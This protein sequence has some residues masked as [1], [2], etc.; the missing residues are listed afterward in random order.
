MWHVWGR[1]EMHVRFWR[2]ILTEIEYL[3]DLGIVWYD[4][5]KPDLKEMGRQGVDSVHLVQ[6]RDN[7]RALVKR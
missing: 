1:I 7:W 3:E 4:D 6:D 5:N 2:G